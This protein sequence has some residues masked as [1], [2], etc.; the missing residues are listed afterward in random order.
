MAIEKFTPNIKN[1]GINKATGAYAR[2][3]IGEQANWSQVYG[4]IDKSF[5]GM[6]GAI[7]QTIAIDKALLK[8]LTDKDDQ[9]KK[10]I[11]N[12][13]ESGNSALD[14]ASD[15]IITDVSGGEKTEWFQLNRK[16]KKEAISKLNDVQGVKNVITSVVS[17]IG[18]GN[19][20]DLNWYN[21]SKNVKVKEFF[22]HI[23]NN[24][25]APGTDLFTLDTS[26]NMPV[27]KFAGKELD[28]QDLQSGA[29]IF[30]SG[31]EMKTS[32]KDLLEASIDNGI[33]RRDSLAN[34]PDSVTGGK[35]MDM[36]RFLQESRDNI[37]N[38]SEA[39]DN[40]GFIFNNLTH[41]IDPNN[42]IDI[43]DPN[44][45]QH[46]ADVDQYINNYIL[47]GMGEDPQIDLSAEEKQSREDR[48]S[49]VTRLGGKAID[50]ATNDRAKELTKVV[51]SLVADP[52][53]QVFEPGSLPKFEENYGK[54]IRT[55]IQP[56]TK[57]LDKAMENY[58]AKDFFRNR[59]ILN[60][61]NQLNNVIDKY[62]NGESLSAN[63]QSV[64]SAYKEMLGG[65]D[66]KVNLK[67]HFDPGAVDVGKPINYD[68]NSKIVTLTL[69]GASSP[70]PFNLRKPTERKKFFELLMEF[71]NTNRETGGFAIDYYYSQ[72]D[73]LFDDIDESKPE[74]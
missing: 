43:Y 27:I 58:I 70:Q 69:K 32:I 3:D 2:G 7:A 72:G 48:A 40:Y 59:G 34:S 12:L 71:K 17:D 25:S 24:E 62:N 8:T 10:G 33:Q 66:E 1:P 61:K 37:K 39:E 23:M 42:R 46:I 16:E 74:L 14:K 68:R 22:N 50:A 51:Q 73:I 28:F 44:N 63:Q 64:L 54:T 31:K 45:E 21:F 36:E 52:Q 47:N 26:G 65:F 11:A 9:F 55:G 41:V 15:Q 30:K 57:A 5:Q 4:A 49:G 56:K 53:G 18:T 19:V 20:E 6:M 35:K 60:F 13:Q 67:Q 29:T 38:L